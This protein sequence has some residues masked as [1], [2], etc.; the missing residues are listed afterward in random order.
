MKKVPE[1]MLLQV[2]R[3]DVSEGD[4]LVCKITGVKDPNL[5][6][7]HLKLQAMVPK[8]VEVL[9]VDDKVDFTIITGPE[10]AKIRGRAG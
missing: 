2:A 4:L 7:A 1:R 3:L 5:R 10:L 6:D 8:G 9:V